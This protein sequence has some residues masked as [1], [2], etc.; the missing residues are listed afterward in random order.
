MSIASNAK[1]TQFTAAFVMV[2]SRNIRHSRFK[3]T[4]RAE[5]YYVYTHASNV[6]NP[7]IPED[8]LMRE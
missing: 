3:E 8:S 2:A 4:G 6:Q 7:G 5:T 1:A